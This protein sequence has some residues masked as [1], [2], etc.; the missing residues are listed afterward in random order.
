MANEAVKQLTILYRLEPGCLGPDGVDHIEAFCLL[1]QKAL[2][3]KGNVHYKWQVVPR[4]DKSKPEIQFTL[5]G[6]S[7][8]EQ[9]AQKYLSMLTIE[10]DNVI[11]GFEDMLTKM[12]NQYIARKA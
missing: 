7:L 6:K 10:L 2:A 5:N 9:Q 8:T 11:D 12:I 3:A 1:V 4:F